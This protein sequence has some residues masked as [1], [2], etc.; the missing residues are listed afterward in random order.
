MFKL[1]TG[2][3]FLWIY[4][5]YYPKREE[6]DVFKYYDDAIVL[7][8]VYDQ[9]KSD[10]FALLTGIG[11]VDA[12]T[13]RYLQS[14]RYWDSSPTFSFL[15]DNRIIIR[16]NSIILFFSSG[17]I[18]L[19]LSVAIIVS[20]I[21]L[22]FLFLYFNELNLINAKVLYTILF[23][24][25]SLLFWTSSILKENFLFLGLGMFLWTFEKIKK[26]SFTLIPFTILSLLLV[27]FSKIYVAG[28]LF[29]ALAAF[30]WN[31]N[32]RDGKAFWRYSVTF[33]LYAGLILNI[34]YFFPSFNILSI[35]A[36]KQSEFI[37][38]SDWIGAKSVVFVPE[39]SSNVIS[40][41]QAIP[42]ALYNSLLRP[43]PWDYSNLL[44]IPAIAELFVILLLSLTGIIFFKRPDA[45]IANFILFSTGFILSMS[46][47]IGWT[48]PVL[49]A[50]VRYKIVFLP[51]L[52]IALVSIVDTSR[53]KTT[54]NK[55][56][57]K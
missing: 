32:K 50:I 46:L 49:G 37:C 12:L 8:S 48:S 16:F 39:L 35:L 20:F 43:M 53:I 33:A 42:Y 17:N 4:T 34:D 54:I 44:S 23:F 7:N 55:F 57:L 10:Y 11:D 9:S 30:E 27:F 51:F 52:L 2:I 26:G 5:N 19:H 45:R 25:P 21:G 13:K 24:T 36:S 40:F 14:S 38:L 15:N 28:T 18:Y 31:K 29:P 1:I 56:Q 3:I 6:A 22:T 41:I 47:L